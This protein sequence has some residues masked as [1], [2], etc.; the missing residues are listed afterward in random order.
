MQYHIFYD[1]VRLDEPIEAANAITAAASEIVE[2]YFPLIKEDGEYLG[3]IDAN[4]TTL[5][6]M[7]SAEEGRYWVEVPCPGEKGSYGTFLDFEEIRGMLMT[8]SPTIPVKGL[9]E[10][11][12]KGW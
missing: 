11:T 10:F 9:P 7:Y 12:F 1:A 3:I 4:G 8:L 2:D 5:Q 6:L